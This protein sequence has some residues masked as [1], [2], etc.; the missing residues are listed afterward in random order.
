M[1]KS[2]H[3]IIVALLCILVP[4]IESFGPGTLWGLN[5]DSPRAMDTLGDIIRLMKLVSVIA[6]FLLLVYY[7]QA[8]AHLFRSKILK[9]AF[10]SIIYLLAA[11]QVL[12]LGLGTLLFGI[13]APKDKIHY[14]QDIAQQTFYVY[15]ADPGAFAKAYHH[16]YLKCPLP[17]NRYELKKLGKVGWLG[18]FNI[19]REMDEVVLRATGNSNEP[20]QVYRLALDGMTCEK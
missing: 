20:I 14:E 5:Y 17:F 6:G 7:R 2:C 1:Q 3:Y 10:Y 8:V 4:L 11:I 18:A 12:L 15:T 16:V 13:M 9:F 19:E